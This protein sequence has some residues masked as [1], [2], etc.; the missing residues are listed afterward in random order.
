MKKLTFAIIT[1]FATTA[2][3]AQNSVGFRGNLT[4]SNMTKFDLIENITPDFKG[5]VSG[6]G[7]IFLEIP[8]TENFSVQPEFSFMEKGFAV[9]EGINVGGAFLN[10]NINIPVNGKLRFKTDYIQVPLLA[11]YHFGDKTATHAYVSAGPAIGY[12]ADAGV[13]IR[14]LDIFPISSNVSTDIFKPFE[15][16]GIAAVGF[17]TPISEKLMCFVEGRYEHGFSRVL[18]TP[19]IQLPVRN[20]TASGSFGIKINL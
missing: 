9:K 15:F 17:E 19:I 18:D 10:T 2:T 11:K 4:V 20:R 6:G 3:F 13:T 12:M 16:S 5:L 1:L 7:A 14:V 8:V